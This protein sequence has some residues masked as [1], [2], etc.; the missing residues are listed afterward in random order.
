MNGMSQLIIQ[1]VMA[2]FEGEEASPSLLKA[3]GD[4]LSRIIFEKTG[5]VAS[6]QVDIDPDGTAVIIPLDP[7]AVLLIHDLENDAIFAEKYTKTLE[8]MI[9]VDHPSIPYL[10]VLFTEETSPKVRRIPR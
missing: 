6:F 1:R 8:E 9:C 4:S 3:M 5:L 7:V 2:E 10:V